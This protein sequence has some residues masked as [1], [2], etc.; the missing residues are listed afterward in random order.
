MSE[1]HKATTSHNPAGAGR[2]EVN[3]DDYRMA[4]DHALNAPDY[5]YFIHD[6]ARIKFAENH[7]YG[8]PASS[9]AVVGIVMGELW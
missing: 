4:L 9:F 2:I 6:A 1:N 8:K 3:L 5:G 7:A